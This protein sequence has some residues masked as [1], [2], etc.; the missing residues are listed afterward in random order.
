MVVGRAKRR[1]TM[2]QK[3][4]RSGFPAAMVIPSAFADH[5]MYQHYYD[6]MNDFIQAKKEGGQLLHVQCWNV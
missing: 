5:I 4:T 1:A 3:I 6:I 2:V